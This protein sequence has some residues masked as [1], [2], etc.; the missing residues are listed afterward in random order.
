MATIILDPG[1]V[2]EHFHD[3]DSIS[4]LNAGS[5]EC[6]FGGRT[7][8]MEPGVRVHIPARMSHELRNVGGTAAEIRCE[9]GVNPPPPPGTWPP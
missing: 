3:A 8:A 6:R 1:E 9:H 7:I 5:V 2:F 4:I